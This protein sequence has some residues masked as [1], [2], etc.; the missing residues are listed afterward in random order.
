MKNTFLKCFLV[1]TTFFI[2]LWIVDIILPFFN[3][4]YKPLLSFLQVMS[5]ILN[6]IVSGGF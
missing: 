6:I 3:P 5:T 4:D 1:L 2:L